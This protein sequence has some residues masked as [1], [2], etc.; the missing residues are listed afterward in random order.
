MLALHRWRGT[1]RKDVSRY[2][3]L[4]QLCR[5]KFTSGGLPAERLR[6]KPNFVESSR[7]PHWD[8]RK[9][10]I[11]IG[12]LS[13]EKGIEILAR[14]MSK[15][16]QC[17][18]DVYGKGPLQ[19]FVEEVPGLRYGGFQSPSQLIERLHGA[20]FVIV[21]S[22]GVE[23]FGLVAIEAFACGTPVIATRHGGLAELVE[24]GKTGLLVTPG[25]AAELAGAISWAQANPAAMQDMG[26][27]AREEYLARYTPEH[28]YDILLG[29]YQE[30]INDA[31]CSRV[32]GK[33]N[34]AQQRATVAAGSRTC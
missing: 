12:R 34:D 30:A 22:T 24:H 4:N 28:N 29:I 11:F 6:I 5:D 8:K 13:T 27:A 15:L 7:V 32:D 3:V 33:R 10:G 1:W 18:I 17:R 31:G 26:R 21:P 20:A 16:P 14:A 25:D 9:G 23:S 19:A 2:I